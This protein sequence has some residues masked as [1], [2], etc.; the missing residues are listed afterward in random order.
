MIVRWKRR[1]RAG[2]ETRLWSWRGGAVSNRD[3][4]LGVSAS[5][6]HV[7]YI[8]CDTAGSWSF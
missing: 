4:G 1:R 6:V 7:Y 3:S 2:M 8:Q 5:I